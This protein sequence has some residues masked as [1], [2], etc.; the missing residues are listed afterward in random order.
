[1]T[2]N[3]NENTNRG[4]MSPEQVENL[5]RSIK[6]DEA[7]LNATS[8]FN[9]ESD[10]QPV[11]ATELSVD[12]EKIR[13]RI[14]SLQ[15]K[16]DEY[17][18]KVITDPAKRDAIFKRRKEIEE[19]ISPW[20]ETP[21]ELR[22][23]MNDDHWFDACEKAQ[24]RLSDKQLQHDIDEWKN[25]GYMLDNKDPYISSLDRLRIEIYKRGRKI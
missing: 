8:D 9:S 13:K 10:F 2:K 11:S 22:S 16:L 17:E 7:M 20:I 25:L 5:K 19:K 1:M 14:A 21:A 15:A 18:P 12:K 6:Q 3:T 24:K 23:Q 4:T